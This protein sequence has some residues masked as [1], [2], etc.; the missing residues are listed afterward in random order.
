MEEDHVFL[1]LHHAAFLVHD[2]VSVAVHR[3]ENDWD[4]LVEIAG[5]LQLNARKHVSVVEPF[6]GH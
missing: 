1:A 5:S 6:F 4:R 3:S 2:P